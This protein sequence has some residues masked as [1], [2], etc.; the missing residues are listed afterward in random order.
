MEKVVREIE[1]DLNVKVQRLDVAR[2]MSAERLYSLLSQELPPLLYHR[3]SKQMIQLRIN[4]D[5]E[6]PNLRIDRSRVRAWAKGRRLS[7]LPA[8]E[9]GGAPLMFTSEEAGIDQEELMLDAGM[10]PLQRKGRKAIKERTDSL[11]R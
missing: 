10:T 4:P 9:G 5:E 3:E 7:T 8:N 11:G 6:I 1:K 2:D